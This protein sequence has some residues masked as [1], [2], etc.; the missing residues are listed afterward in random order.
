[1][2]LVIEGPAVTR[3]YPLI[4][5][6]AILIETLTI[7]RN[8]TLNAIV[9]LVRGGDRVEIELRGAFP[10]PGS[11]IQDI[12]VSIVQFV[13]NNAVPLILSLPLPAIVDYT[14]H[15]FDLVEHLRKLR[16]GK[17]TPHVE[18]ANRETA[19]VTAENEQPFEVS[20]KALDSL[21]PAIELLAQLNPDRFRSVELRTR[22]GAA[23]SI[24]YEAREKM[25]SEESQQLRAVAR[26]LKRE[27]R[28]GGLIEL[29][30]P[31]IPLSTGDP[32]SLSG[33]IRELDFDSKSGRFHTD[34]DGTVR[35]GTYDFT[36]V[37]NQ[38]LT[39][40]RDL[41]GEARVIVVCIVER[42]GKKVRLYANS[43]RN[44]LR[45]A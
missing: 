4:E 33:T 40:I 9:P 24:R 45:S 26:S 11:Y 3:S 7:L 5:V 16:R 37:G 6:S 28:Q 41:M 21:N 22:D 30:E 25:T 35:E 17:K 42:R 20:V 36:I 18:R 2:T 27:A 43:I 12:G 8:S 19:V 32:I 31:L 15:V 10:H 1:M 39:S 38:S 13:H 23:L 44:V 29:T 34:G 14:N